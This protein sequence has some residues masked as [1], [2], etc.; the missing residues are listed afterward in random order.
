MQKI[1]GQKNC[2]F[3]KTGVKIFKPLYAK[4]HKSEKKSQ[5]F[6]KKSEQCKNLQI[7]N[8]KIC[9]RKMQICEYENAKINEG[10]Y[11]NSK[12]SVQ[13]LRKRETTLS[14]QM[15]TKISKILLVKNFKSEKL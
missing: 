14:I 9:R 4:N 1:I 5:V 10:I 3:S 2:R 13:F 12:V 11:C 8:G 7:F 15:S 6:N